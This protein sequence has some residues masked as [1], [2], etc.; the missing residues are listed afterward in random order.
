MAKAR[1]QGGVYTLKMGKKTVE[2]TQAELT[3]KGWRLK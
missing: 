1:L 2:G 3:E